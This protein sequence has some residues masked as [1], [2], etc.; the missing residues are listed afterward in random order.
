MAEYLKRGSEVAVTEAADREVRGTVEG[1]I[2]A[3]KAGGDGAVRE[4][5]QKF[6]RWAPVSFR[7]SQ[8]ELRSLVASVSPDTIPDI[9]FA[10]SQ[11]RRFAEHQRAALSAIEVETLPGV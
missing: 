5:S 10:Q 6:D 7:L 8:D 1:I 2:A 9:K 3:V 4:L 11:I